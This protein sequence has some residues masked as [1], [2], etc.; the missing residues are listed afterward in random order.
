MSGPAG[1]DDPKGVLNRVARESAGFADSALA[2]ASESAGLEDPAPDPIERWGRRI[3]RLLGALF[4]VVL[5]L[6]LFTHWF[7]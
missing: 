1:A 2:R 6:N 5:I 4:F 3:G 7:F